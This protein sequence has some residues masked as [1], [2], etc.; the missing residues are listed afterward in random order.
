MLMD[1]CIYN[2]HV[3]GRN[4]VEKYLI[5]SPPHEDSDEMVCLR[6]MQHAIFS[7]F[8][9]ES[10]EPGVAL[11]VRNMVSNE[12]V[13]LV[14]IGLSSSVEPGL[15]FAS[16]LQFYDGFAMTTGITLPLGWPAKNEIRSLKKERSKLLSPDKDGYTDPAPLINAF[17]MQGCAS[18]ISFRHPPENRNVEP[19]LSAR[20]HRPAK[21]GRN[22]PCPCGSGRKYKHCC[23][24]HG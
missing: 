11:T 16:R 17:L 21:I 18:R 2:I 5:D 14:D 19:R 24:K 1:Y 6:A 4:A 22:S 12:T 3:N 7:L 23:E 10:V 13:L 15:A 20:E 9:V 8:V